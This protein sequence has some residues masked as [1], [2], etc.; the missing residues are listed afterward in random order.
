[1][2]SGVPYDDAK[3]GISQS[4]EGVF[5]PV[6]NNDAAAIYWRHQFF[7]NAKVK[8]VRAIVKTA[9]KGNTS[10]I[11]VYKGT[12]SIGSIAIGTAT[13]G[14]KV[15]A[16]LTDTDFDKDTDILNLGQAVATDTGAAFI[17][18]EYQEAYEGA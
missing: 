2:G 11:T 7:V 15:D 1:M 14:T 12:T 4:A 5:T 17:A 18:V 8:E 13:A 16:S 10:A 6:E 3:F 9:G